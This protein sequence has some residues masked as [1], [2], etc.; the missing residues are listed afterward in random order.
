VDGS[1]AAR[2]GSWPDLEYTVTTIP[3]RDVTV[4]MP[5]FLLPL[6]LAHGLPVDETHGGTIALPDLPGFALEIAPGSV[7]FPGGSKSGF[8]S[9]TAVHSDKVPMVPNFGQQ[10]RLI[11]TIQPAGA[12]FEPPA[13]LSLPNVEGLAA[14]QVTEMYSFDHDLGHFVSIG[15]ATVSDDGSVIVANP[16]VGIVKAGWH[17]GGNPGSSGISHNCPQCQKCEMKKACCV[18]DPTKDGHSCDDKDK[19]TVNDKCKDGDCKGDT[20]RVT[21][22]QAPPYVCVGNTKPLR[23]T[24]KPGNRNIVWRSRN[25]D[26]L[27]IAGV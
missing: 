20:V 19:C 18:P 24:I 22:I 14:G 27:S 6:D 13:R 23:A 5:I 2:P 16:G 25:P 12:R 26:V 11:V 4:N 1:T 7:T 17:C 10:P 3:G 8:V 21:N 9:V 15:P